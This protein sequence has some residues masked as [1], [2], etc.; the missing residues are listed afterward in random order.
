[1][2]TKDNLMILNGVNLE[3]DKMELDKSGLYITDKA[4]KY[5]YYVHIYNWNEISSI[6]VGEKQNMD[7]NEYTFSINND[8]VLIWPTTCYVD[9]ITIDSLVF[10][11]KFDDFSNACVMNK[12]NKLDFELKSLEIKVYSDKLKVI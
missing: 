12:N 3:I 10:Y 7:F 1:M 4:G 6:P 8:S 2:C 9:R 11:F 5:S